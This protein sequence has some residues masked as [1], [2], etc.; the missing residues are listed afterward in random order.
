[1]AVSKTEVKHV[2]GKLGAT[3]QRKRKKKNPKNK[4][5]NPLNFPEKDPP[6]DKHKTEHKSNIQ[7]QSIF[8]S[9]IMKIPRNK[10]K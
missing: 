8:Y 5:K 6:S 7:N 1:M 9:P 4:T 2:P 10:S 3:A